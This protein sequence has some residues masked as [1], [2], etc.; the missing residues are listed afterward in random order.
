MRYTVE[1]VANVRLVFS[2]QGI[3]AQDFVKLTSD[4]PKGAVMDISLAQ[5]VGAVMAMGLPADLNAYKLTNPPVSQEIARLIAE[6]NTRYGES[7][8]ARQITDYLSGYD[9]GLS[10]DAML[11]ASTGIQVASGKSDRSAHPLD[12]HDMGR[13]RRLYAS[14]NFVRQNLHKVGELSESWSLLMQDLDG[15]AKTQNVST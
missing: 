9:R 7:E 4:L 8:D 10:A 12:E 1:E 5:R 2:E 13:C 15:S 14:C 11:Q 3:P 6:V